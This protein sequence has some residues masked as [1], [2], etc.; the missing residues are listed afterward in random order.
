M[1]LDPA[2]ALDVIREIDRLGVLIAIDDFGSGYSSLGYLRDLPVHA[3]K[4]DKSF[5]QNMRESADDRVIVESTV[6]MAH[7]LKLKVV[8]E[9]V[10][11]D[12]DARF[13]A[14]AGYDYGQGYVFSKAMAAADCAEWITRFNAGQASAGETRKRAGGSSR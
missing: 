7:A 9:G 2:R 13:L 4:L 1:M 12:W 11:S 8:A 6:Q 14:A 5:V 3:L 10:E